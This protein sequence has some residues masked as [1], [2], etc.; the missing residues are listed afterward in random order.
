LSLWDKLFC[1]NTHNRWWFKF[2]GFS[3]GDCLG[4]VSHLWQKSSWSLKSPILLPIFLIS[5]DRAPWVL[6]PLSM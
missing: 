2:C 4:S 5:H 3:S 6:W 1:L